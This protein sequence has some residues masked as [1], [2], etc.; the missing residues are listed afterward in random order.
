MKLIWC[1]ARVA[2]FAAVAFVI[3]SPAVPH[4]NVAHAQNAND[5]LE[6]AA[7]VMLELESFHFVISTPVGET[8]LIDEVELEGIE[9]DVQRPATFHATFTVALPFFSLGL[10]AIGHDGQLWVSD[11]FTGGDSFIRLGGGDDLEGQVPPELI[12]NPDQLVLRAIELLQDATVIGEEEVQGTPAT[13]IEGTFDLSDILLE[14][15]PV[16][17]SD[18]VEFES[19]PVTLWLDAEL[20]VIRAEFAGPILP[21]EAPGTE[22]VRRVDLSAFNEP[23]EIEL[24]ESA[25]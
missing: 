10:E 25:A 18:E 9:G 14:G 7:H 4:V 3:A 11:P 8:M 13:R 5:I 23:V 24:P 19:I 16:A 6:D 15:T 2:I 12:L 17:E 21:T 22:I 1:R 20:R